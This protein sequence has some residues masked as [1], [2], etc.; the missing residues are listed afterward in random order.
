MHEVAGSATSRR[1]G[2]SV[3]DGP[4][5][6]VD[7]GQVLQCSFPEAT[8]QACR[9]MAGQAYLGHLARS[10]VQET[11]LSLP[12]L[13]PAGCRASDKRPVGRG[14]RAFSEAERGEGGMGLLPLT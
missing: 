4:L 2:S 13:R 7:A 3:K 11:L 10:A 9:R 6:T 14:L 8:V 1:I 5:R 12:E